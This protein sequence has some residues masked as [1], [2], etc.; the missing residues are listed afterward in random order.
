MALTLKSKKSAE[1]L[2]HGRL[3]S[4]INSMAD[5]VIAVDDKHKVVVYNGAALDIWT[6]T[7]LGLEQELTS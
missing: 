2:D 7:T 3:T 1:Q 6:S 4:L 5:A